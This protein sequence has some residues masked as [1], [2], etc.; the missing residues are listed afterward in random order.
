MSEEILFFIFRLGNDSLEF[1]GHM[2]SDEF[3]WF[4]Q[5][6]VHDRDCTVLLIG[7]F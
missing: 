6:D 2:F 1:D 5:L 3:L 7:H 4:E